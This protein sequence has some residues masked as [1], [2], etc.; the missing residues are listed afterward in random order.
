MKVSVTTPSLNQAQYLTHTLESVLSQ[1]GEFSIE[2]FVMDGGSTD[3]SIEILRDYAAR[4]GA[5]AYP[6]RCRGI[7]FDWVSEPDKGQ[8]DA[9]NK[10]LR[11][12]SGDIAAYINSDDC[13]LPGAFATI[14]RTLEQNPESDFVYGDGNVI[15]ETGAVQWEWLARPYNHRILT[16]YHFLWNEFTNYLMQQA[17]FWRKSA[18]DAI[19]YFDETLHYSMDLEYW[20]RAGSSGLTLQHIPEKIAEFRLI[21]GTKSL[22]DPLAFWSDN[23]ELFRRYRSDSLARFFAYYF[24]NF[25]LHRDFDLHALDAGGLEVLERWSGLP[26]RERVERDANRGLAKAYALIALELQ[27]RGRSDEA[28]T[29][30]RRASQGPLAGAGSVGLIYQLKKAVGAR[31][32]DAINRTVDS[33]IR[34]YKRRKYDYRYH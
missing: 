26:D 19:G 21:Q 30:Y 7:S 4:L 25:A 31:G 20:L 32:A 33:L 2:Y 9:I 18:T 6:V 10:G 22:S 1:E 8:S 29:A 14:T 27:R 16:S 3:G 11:R 23:L 15:D 34:K 28:E 12:S 13:Y 17:V 24:Y 5:G